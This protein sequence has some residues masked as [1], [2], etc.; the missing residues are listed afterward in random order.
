MEKKRKQELGQVDRRQFL[1]LMSA[2]GMTA[3]VGGMLGAPFSAD[4]QEIRQRVIAQ[5]AKEKEKRRSAK[6]TMLFA[7]GGLMNRWPKGSVVKTSVELIGAWQL[8]EGIERKS[9]GE[10]VINMVEGAKL[11]AQTR[12]AKKLQQGVIDG[13]TCSTQNVAGLIP[14]WNVTDFPYTIGEEENYWKLL[15]S[16]EFND[17]VRVES[18]QKGIMCLYVFAPHRWFNLRKGISHE[19]RRPEHLKGLK[20]RVTGSKLEQEALKVLPCNPTPIAW[21]ETYS[22]MKEGAIDGIH[23]NVAAQSDFGFHEVSGQIIDSGFMFSSDATWI[24]TKFYRKLSS[25]LQEAVL[26]SAYEGTV[27]AQDTFEPFHVRQIGIR[28][29]SPPDSIWK[30]AKVKQV[31]LTPAEKEVWKD[32]L[33]YD[34]NKKRYAPLVKRFGQK[35]FETVLRVAQA[36]GKPEKRRWWKA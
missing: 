25:K 32:W 34:R 31:I 15:Y 3:T 17:L 24:G 27:F 20:I 1:R 2:Y 22:A 9:K 6:Y 21:G 36:P 23:V 8:K 7:T 28:P 13:C 5:A 16:K 19:V 26:E 11:G 12:L 33:A 18:M 10:I 30:K 14:V 29:N 35:E 4:A